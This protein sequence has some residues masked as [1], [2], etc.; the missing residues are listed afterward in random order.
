MANVYG[1]STDGSDSDTGSS[2]T[3]AKATLNSIAGIDA[4]GDNVYLSQAHAESTAGAISLTWQGTTASP[5]KIMCANDSAEPPTST[6]TTATVTTTTSGTMTL[7]AGAA[8]VVSY[9]GITFVC[10]SGQ[11]SNLNINASGSSGSSTSTQF[12]NCIFRIAT[13]GSG[14]YVGFSGSN[15]S[16]SILED[17]WVR[18]GSTAQ[19][20]NTLGAGGYCIWNGGG[21]E[22]GGSAITTMWGNFGGGNK[23][24]LSGLDLSAGASAMNLAN[25]TVAGIDFVMRN[26]K[27]PASWSGTLNASTPGAGSVFELHNCDSGDTNYRFIRQTQFGTVRN[28]TTIVRTGGASDGTTAFSLRMA[29]NADAEYPV[30]TLDTPELPAIWNS[31]VGSAITVAV[32]IVTDGVTLTDGECWIELQYLGTSGY[33]L[34]LFASD[35]KADYLGSAA[36]QTSSSVAWTTTGLS[37]PLKQTLSVTVTPQEVGYLHAVVRLAKASTTVYVDPKMTVS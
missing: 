33:P 35:A 15:F 25:S 6:A 27:L 37:S 23:I 20:C 17:C 12:K 26:C 21:I 9:Y 29:S 32:E 7:N 30:L 5:V 1:R 8:A 19:Q 34:S 18:F 14:G 22:A 10:G 28:E 13:T 24:R 36:N 16:G 3:L 2:W 31:T 11:S 4:A